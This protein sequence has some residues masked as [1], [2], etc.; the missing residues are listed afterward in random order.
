[1]AD[2]RVCMDGYN[3]KQKWL[4]LV[5]GIIV[6]F[7]AIMPGISGGTLCVAFGMYKPLIE[8]FSKPREGLKK[9]WMILSLFIVGI[10]V[11]FIGLSGVAGW[12]MGKNSNAVTCAFIGFV[13]G[14]FPELW[15]D[16]GQEGR[17][18]SSFTALIAGFIIMLVLLVFLK[19]SASMSLKPD[20]RGFFLCGI[21]WGLS[22]VVPGLSSSTLL[23]FFGLYQPM[24]DG[25]SS[26]SV[27]VLIPLSAGAG[28]CLAVLP[29]GVNAAYER[30]YSSISH[31]VLGIVAATTVMI[32]PDFRT[33]AVNLI[34]YA[35]CIIGGAA[36]SY[37]ISKACSNLECSP[38]PSEKTAVN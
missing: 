18:R 30:F 1:M 17:R 34:L 2:E 24:L 12:L 37:I 19:S 8:V 22:F 21:M 23:L 5:K 26:F 38:E 35:V 4:L 32:F 16:A 6:G 31:C 10:A 27:K 20:I 11:G 15:R 9:Y 28:L 3:A 25:I 7:G 29:R 36:V 33:G 14:T 13:I